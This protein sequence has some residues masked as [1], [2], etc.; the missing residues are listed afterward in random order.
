MFRLLILWCVGCATIT[1]LLKSHCDNN[2]YDRVKAIHLKQLRRVIYCRKDIPANTVITSEYLELRMIPKDILP[3]N[4]CDCSSTAV[5]RKT[6]SPVKKGSALL[7]AD[8]GLF[9]PLHPVSVPTII[10]PH[11]QAY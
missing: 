7:L 11:R 9:D 6:R 1:W 8:L 10:I 4:A 3:L 2:F 5:G